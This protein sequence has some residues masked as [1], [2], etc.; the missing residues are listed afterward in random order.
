MTPRA[1]LLDQVKTPGKIKF[2]AAASGALL[3]VIGVGN[4]KVMGANGEVV[5]LGNVLLVEGLSAN[6][7]SVHR[8][9]K[10]KAEVTFGPTSCRAKL[11]K[12]LLW[13]LEEKSSCIKDL[14][15]L[16]IIPWKGKPPAIAKAAGAAKATAGGEESAPTAAAMDAVKK[17]QQPQQPHREV[18]AGVDAT[19]AWAKASSGSGEADWEMWH[20]RL[21]HVNIPMLQ[22][23]VKDGCLKGL[24]VKGGAKE[25]GNCPTCLETKFTKFPFSSSTGPAKAPLA[26]VHMDVV[27]P[28]RAL[29]L[30]GSRYFLT[31]VDDHTRAVWVY[32]LKTKGEVAAA[33]LKE[34]MPR[35][36][37]ESGHKVKVI[38][39]D[40]GGEF[41]GADVEKELK[42]KGIQHQL[43]VPYNP[44][45]NGVAERFN[46]TLQ[47]GA[48][49]LIGRAGL[50]DPF[51][52]TALRQVVVV[53]NREKRGKLEASG[54]WGVHLGLA[55]D[56][57]GWLIWDLTSQQL[58]VSRD[59]KFL[60]SLYYKEWKQQQ[61]QKLP[62]TPLIVEADEVQRP[63]RQ[64]E[65]SVSKEE[66][67]GVTDDGGEPEVE[68]QQQQQQEEQG[69]PQ[70]AG[71]T[72][73]RPRRD[74]RPPNRLTYA[75]RGKPKVAREAGVRAR[76]E[77]GGYGEADLEILL[78]GT[79]AQW[80][81]EHS[82]P[83]VEADGASAS[84]RPVHNEGDGGDVVGGGSTRVR[85]VIWPADGSGG[86]M[87]AQVLRLSTTGGSSNVNIDG[88]RQSPLRS[89]V[90]PTSATH[91]SAGRDEGIAPACGYFQ[92]WP[93]KIVVPKALEGRHELIT[94]IE[95][96]EP[97]LEITGLK[98][99]VDGNVA[100]PDADDFELWTEFDAAHLLT[101]MV[102]SSQLEKKSTNIRMGEHESAA[103]YCNR[104][105]R[106]LA[107]LRMVD[108]DY[109]VALYVTHVFCSLPSGYNLMRRML[110]IPGT[111][112]TLNEDSLWSHIIQDEFM[113]ESERPA[114]LLPQANYVAPA[115]QGHQQ[116]QRGKSG[117]GGG[118][119]SSNAKSTEGADRGKSAKGGDR[120]SSG[121]RREG[122]RCYICNAPDHLSYDSPNRDESDDDRGANRRKRDGGRRRRDNQPR[123]EKQASKTTSTKDADSSGG[124]ARGK[125][126]SC[127]MVS[128]V[129]P[130]LSLALEAGK[131]FKAVAASVQT[132]PT[133]VLLDSGCSYHLM[134][135]KEAFVDMQP[136][137]D[138]RHVRG[139]NGALQS[140]EGRDTV[141]LQGEAGKKTCYVWVRPIA[142]KSDVLVVF[143]MWLKEVER[144]TSK[145]VKKLCSDR[146]G[147]FLSR[148]FTDL[149]EDKGILHNLT[150]PYTLQ[151]NGM[152]ERE[153]C[154]VVEA[155]RTMY[156]HMGVKHHWW[157]LALRQAVWVRNCLE[158]DSLPKGTTLH[159]LLLGKKPDLTLARM[160]G[161][162][163]QFMVPEQQR[164]GKLAPKARWGLHLG[165]SPESKGWEVLDL[166]DNKIV[167]TGEAIFY[168]HLLM[169]KWTAEY[170]PAS[171]RTP[172]APPPDSSSE[173]PPLL[174]VVDKL[175]D[176]D[177]EEVPLPPPVVPS[178]AAGDEGRLD[179]S[180]VA[181]TGCIAGGLH[182]VQKV[183]DGKQQT[184]EE[185]SASKPTSEKP[186][187]ELPPASKPLA[188]APT[189]GEPLVEKPIVK[190][191]SVEELPAGEQFDDDSSS[192]D[193]VEEKPRRSTRPNIGKPPEKLSYHAC[194]P[195]T[196]YNTLLDDAEDNIDLPELDPDM[197][198][199]REHS[200]DIANMT[201]K[202]AL[203]SW[204]GKAV[205]T[206]KYHVD[207]TVARKKARLVVKGFT[208][209]YGADYDKTY[210]P[211]GSYVALQI[212]LSIVAVLDLHLMQLDM[213]N[214]FLQSKL[215]RVLYMYQPDY[216]NDGIGR[217]CKLLKS[218]YGLKQ[219]LLLW[220]LALDAVLTGANWQK[221][222]ADEALYFKVGD[223]GVACWVLVYVDNTAI[224]RRCWRQAESDEHGLHF[225]YV[226]ATE[227]GNEARRLR[228]LLAEFRLFDPRKPTVLHVD[229]QSAITV[230]E[231][232]RLKGNLKHMERRYAWLQRMV[233]RGK[234]ALQYIPTTEQP[235]DF[236]T[237]AL[238]F[239]ALNRCSVAIDQVR[240]AD[241][242]DGDNEVQQ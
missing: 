23:L 172:S 241:V 53:K 242:G 13:N 64:V 190:E 135:T 146:G 211:V 130:M 132:N 98:K 113:Q 107:D 112:E 60:E 201:V 210:A 59:V 217:V 101:F 176:E 209:I 104:V 171:T 161:C 21:C 234:I 192:D 165:V 71:R 54:R 196:T 90:R 123:K 49:T 51:W 145:T 83:R 136:S 218:L 69:A 114:E 227:A 52:V 109:S 102:I 186:S 223:D 95:S 115:K 126:T 220:Y 124:N 34:W 144:Q 100:T 99:F 16:P 93:D 221:S 200:W 76:H 214:A 142:K 169:E 96:I 5:G 48:R 239:A 66:I 77:A 131:D 108:V 199:N 91:L 62:M 215:D 87:Q 236:L 10:S 4:A 213:K 216:F 231:G 70:G 137:G 20:E 148:A 8:L 207:D 156:L 147:E 58:T 35:A 163:V 141:A 229:N 57:K 38:R 43:T 106:V 29:S 92:I 14:W 41:I 153:M 189:S 233:K 238:H 81:R 205:L 82:P 97:Q 111:R 226:A 225:Q 47:E 45:Q 33:V 12:M 24:E 119:K 67:S 133:V 2:V 175:D 140:V 184:T 149:V 134:G 61:Q 42:R 117:G 6:L 198:A 88:R 159:E 122:R 197:H 128:M 224:C 116:G 187:G 237:K 120:G 86:G 63:S 55:K 240:M 162:M 15:Q 26:L 166:T 158:R 178:S 1:D 28:T 127:S 110:T 203:A 228:F 181:P 183:G 50:P 150:Y 173:V 152:A 185:L 182:D 151:Q 27:G 160:W 17:V 232:L 68:Q 78:L 208:Q 193:V 202:E 11:G 73:D 125:E 143:E 3:P 37:R 170:G 36:Q 84:P 94:W 39:T 85:G 9:Q 30:S 194:L 46:R 138:A 56:H 32:P 206:T 19:A 174:A 72:A 212:F 121:S 31:I 164:G 7:L 180:P 235:A 74:V 188:E 105:R 22:K 89:G 18:L 167:T 25:I 40:N 139:F 157:H 191:P 204:K 75:S 79:R 179:A 219:S 65:V 118:W 154:T 222:Q 230:A 177:A 155:V 103:E 168:E 80:A 195:L 44:E 129:E